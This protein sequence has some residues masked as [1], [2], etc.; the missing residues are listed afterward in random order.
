MLSDGNDPLS[1]SLLHPQR[2]SAWYLDENYY[3]WPISHYHREKAS[4]TNCHITQSEKPGLKG[5]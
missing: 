3:C 2:F 4:V 1:L 5:I